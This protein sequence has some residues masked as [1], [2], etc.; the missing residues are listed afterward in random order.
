MICGG[1]IT[2]GRAKAFSVVGAN[3]SSSNMSLRNT[4]SPLAVAMFSPTLN[5]VL[6]TCEGSPRLLSMSLAN[7]RTP[8]ARLRPPVSTSLRSAAGLVRGELLGATA[9]ARSDATKRARLFSRGA[10]SVESMKRVNS[11]WPA[12]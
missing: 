8:L 4:T 3:C 1:D 11:L 12:R 6:S 2:S 10:R 5:G 9:S 7:W